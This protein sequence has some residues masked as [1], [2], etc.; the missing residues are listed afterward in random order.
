MLGSAYVTQ[1]RGVTIGSMVESERRLRRNKISGQARQ[2]EGERD[3]E[4][5]MTMVVE[6]Y[7][8]LCRIPLIPHAKRSCC[9]CGGCSFRVDGPT[10]L[11]S[12]C[13]EHPRRDCEHW[14]V[15]WRGG[16]R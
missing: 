7:C 13:D 16:Y 4:G 8:P 10:L 3:A 5:A 1:S 6:G 12:S 2:N 14:Q 11:M 9:P 15:V